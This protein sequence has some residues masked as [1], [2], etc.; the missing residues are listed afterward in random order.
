MARLFVTALLEPIIF[1]PL[2]VCWSIKGNIDLILGKKSWG[3]M[4]RVGFAK[5]IEKTSTVS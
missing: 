5:K 1:H 2:T 4:S 3:E